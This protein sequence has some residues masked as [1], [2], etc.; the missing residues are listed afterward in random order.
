MAI[1]KYL[2]SFEMLP[3]GMIFVIFKLVSTKWSSHFNQA[4]TLKIK[5]DIF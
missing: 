3:E 5:I 1:L 4:T 2:M